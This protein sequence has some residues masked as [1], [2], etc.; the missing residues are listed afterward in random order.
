MTVTQ[1]NMQEHEIGIDQWLS[2]LEAFVHAHEQQPATLEIF[3]VTGSLLE[4]TSGQLCA[5]KL[6]S[7]HQIQRAFLELHEPMHGHIAHLIANP[8][9]MI[10]RR[11]E[12]H[13]ELEITSADG[14]KTLLRLGSQD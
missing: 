2:F 8:V 11:G 6:D 4:T 14:R 7:K 13:R 1:E 10:I 5:F 9:R 12:L 3:S